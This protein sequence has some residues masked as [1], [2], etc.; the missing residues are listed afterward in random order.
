VE[1]MP[2]AYQF[3]EAQITE[4]T[5][6]QKK[7]RDKSIDKRL[8]ALLMRAAKISRDAVSAKTGFCKQYISDLTASYH[9]NGLSTI[10]EK[11]YGG[12]HRNMSFDDETAVLAP[13]IEAAKAGNQVEVSAILIAYEKKLGRSC[14]KDHGRI[15]RVLARHGWR[16]VMPRSKHPKKANDEAIE[17][18]KKLTLASKK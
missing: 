11:H 10:A 5:I 12:N 9:K 15:Y 1:N 8:E 17:A 18:S 14:E 6:A 3:T 2:K 7:N 16:K 13:F 4:L